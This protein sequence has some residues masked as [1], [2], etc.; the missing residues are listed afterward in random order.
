MNDA[1]ENILLDVSKSP[2]IDGG[3]LEKAS[4]LILASALKGLDIT[5]VSIWLLQSDKQAM[6]AA[7]LIDEKSPNTEVPVLY[8]TSYLLTF[9]R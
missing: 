8:K 7:K 9:R 6:R 2:D 1:L 4:E 3:D 5:V